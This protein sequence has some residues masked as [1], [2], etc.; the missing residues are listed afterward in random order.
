MAK[1]FKIRFRDEESYRQA[2]IIANTV[3]GRIQSR[4][5]REFGSS[6]VQVKNDKR[7]Y[8]SVEPSAQ[9]PEGVGEKQLDQQ[10]GQFDKQLGAEI[11]EDYQYDLET[12]LFD[13]IQ[14]GPDDPNSPT[15]NDV[16]RLI[17]AEEAWESATGKGVTI[18][19]VDT[20]IEG[21]RPEFPEHK[22]AG[23]W[24]PLTEAPWTDWLGHGTMCAA[25]AAGTKSDGGAFN[26]VAPNAS[27]IACKTR[28]FDS[29]LAAIYDYLTDLTQTLG[30]NLI[31]TNSFGEGTGTPPQAP[32]NSDFIPALED[33]INAGVKVFF[34]AGNYHADA[35]GTTE[36]C[37]PTSIWLHK[38]R[39]DVMTVAT[40]N[41]DLEMWFYSSRGPGQHF[42]E[43]NTNAKPD[44]TAPT[45][46]NGKVV[47]GKTLRSLVNGWGTSGACP[48]VA[49][50]AALL[51]SK[52]PDLSREKL[53]EIIRSS[54][55]PINYDA[56][57]C[58]S[59]IINCRKSI[60]SL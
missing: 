51:L 5:M 22:R 34:S 38:C 47:Y 15:L 44:V 9:L 40:C 57:C 11:V 13:P 21:T 58:G 10:L 1:R 60:D 55:L 2:Q 46:V 3:P 16:L 14:F 29:E 23:H 37:G 17:Q 53:F 25:I 28:F 59:G 30:L 12:N 50:L 43:P 41:M 8:L 26:G 20:G 32:E 4:G 42:G 36:N 39:S 48:Q 49:G 6:L 24:E 35:G 27:L 56:T 19:V 33:A 31:A 18:A 7:H 45:P 52:N 54:A